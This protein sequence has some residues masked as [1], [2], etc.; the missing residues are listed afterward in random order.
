MS[1]WGRSGVGETRGGGGLGMFVLGL[2]AGALFL[3]LAAYG[4]MRLGLVDT[5]FLFPASPREAELGRQIDDLRKEL[6]EAEA[7]RPSEGVSGAEIEKLRQ[8][9]E[10]AKAERDELA[11]NAIV[12]ASDAAVLKG[13]REELSALKEQHIP[14]MEAELQQRERLVWE[15]EAKLQVSEKVANDLQNQ[16]EKARGPDV[17]VL[18]DAVDQRDA[19]LKKL[20]DELSARERDIAAL[21][22]END[23]LRRIAPAVPVEQ[24]EPSSPD[25]LERQKQ[26]LAERERLMTQLDSELTARNADVARLESEVAQL[27][28]QLTSG[29][30][31]VL[32]ASELTRKNAELADRDAKLAKAETDKDL[33]RKQVEAALVEA[34]KVPALEQEVASLKA[35]PDATAT[36]AEREAKLREVEAQLAAARSDAERLARENAE[37]QAAVSGAIELRSRLEAAERDLAAARKEA[38]ELREQAALRPRQAEPEAKPA[39]DEASRPSRDPL[40]VANAV[41]GAL[42]LEQ[43]TEQQRDGLAIALIEGACVS[44]ALTEAIGSTP[45]TALKE[46]MQA[47]G[48]DC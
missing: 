42:G 20:D 40:L 41:K 34:D 29:A 21:N 44:T 35:R 25:E 24:A 23:H 13:L 10:S 18:R 19:M 17:Q 5:S 28:K 6:K 11:E 8:E 38:A 27:R 45:E 1:G 16:I 15:L 33:L 22:A 30:P 2:V 43:I 4:S 3:T 36:L 14:E 47:L 48:A 31:E 39:I 7:A 26:E 46:L 37:A 9:L 12:G 32:L